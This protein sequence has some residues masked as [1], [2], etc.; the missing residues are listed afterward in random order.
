MNNEQFD[1]IITRYLQGK[2]T[3]EEEKELL[4]AIRTSGEQV[5]AFRARTAAYPGEENNS[6]LDR[7]WNRIAAVIAPAHAPVEAP[8]EVRP[9]ASFFSLFSR[10]PRL[11]AAAAVI[12]LCLSALTAYFFR[13]TQTQEWERNPSWQT[14][15]TAD[16]DRTCLLPDGT[17]VYLRKGAVLRYANLEKGATRQVAIRGEAFFDVTP[18]A[19]RPFIVQASRLFVKVLG[20][21]FSVSAPEEGETISVILAEGSVSLNDDYQNELVRLTPNQKV[22]YSLGS[23]HYTVSE[24]DSDRATSWRKGIISYD[25]ASL[26]EVVRLIEQT[27]DVSLRYAA[28]ENPEQRFSGAFLKKQ[29]LETVLQLTGRLTGVDL[30]VKK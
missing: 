29:K 26:E 18:D 13:H 9:A 22:D 17:S 27:Y 2:A 24:V 10:R 20:T 8:V 5:E 4:S 6:E 19:R 30:A 7:K 23:G 28:P 21:S 12:L 15:L 25:N 16:D 11:S 14:T 1:Y 3:A